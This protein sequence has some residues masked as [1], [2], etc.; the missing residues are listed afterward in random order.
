VSNLKEWVFVGTALVAVRLRV[1][2]GTSPVPTQY[3]LLQIGFS[4]HPE[5]CAYTFSPSTQIEFLGISMLLRK[6]AADG[7][8]RSFSNIQTEASYYE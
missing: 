6:K 3:N 1:R 5:A 7:G 2:T 8:L 4:T